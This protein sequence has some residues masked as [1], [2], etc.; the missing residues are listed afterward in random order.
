M[1]HPALTPHLLRLRSLLGPSVVDFLTLFS[2]V[3]VTLAVGAAL[4]GEW[5]APGLG[6]KFDQFVADPFLSIFL[7]HRSIWP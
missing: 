5:I 6:A 2:L 7:W 1:Q 4:F 3:V